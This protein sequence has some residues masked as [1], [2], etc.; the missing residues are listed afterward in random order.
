MWQGVFLEK[1]K[2]DARKKNGRA[3]RANTGFEAWQQIAII[4]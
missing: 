1:D 3:R 4:L 2:R